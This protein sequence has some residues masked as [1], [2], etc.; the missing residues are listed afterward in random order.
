MRND[1]ERIRDIRECIEKIEKYSVRGKKEFY[2]DELIQTWIIHNLQIIG[3]ASRA[4]SE[5]F[6]AKYPQV[7]WLKI[8]D[9]RNLLVHEYFRV[10]LG[11]V[12]QIVE[13]ELP[14]LKEQ[15]N[16]ILRDI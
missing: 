13:H 4:T 5:E 12:W 14:K 16:D 1:S 8:A 10:D 9:F 15:I 11:I 3:E 6:K 2:E 7:L